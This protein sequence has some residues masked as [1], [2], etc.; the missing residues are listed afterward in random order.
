MVEISVEPTSDSS[1]SIYLLLDPQQHPTEDLSWQHPARAFVAPITES[2]HARNASQCLTKSD[3]C[4]SAGRQS[5]RCVRS[6]WVCVHLCRCT[7]VPL[8]PPLNGIN[9]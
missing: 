5:A 1:S 4:N 9:I 7:L 2:S 3:A 6:E 8:F